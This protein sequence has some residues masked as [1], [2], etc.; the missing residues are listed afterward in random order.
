SGGGSINIFYQNTLTNSGSIV[1]TGGAGGGSGNYPGGA[2]GTGTTRSIQFNPYQSPAIS[3]NTPYDVNEQTAKIDVT[4]SEDYGKG[5]ST[6]LL[7]WGN[8][9]VGDYTYSTTLSNNAE[10]T[11]TMTMDN[12]DSL[13][14]AKTYYRVTVTN[15]EGKSSPINGN[16][17]VQKSLLTALRGLNGEG[18][19][20]KTIATAYSTIPT[21]YIE[22]DGNTHYTTSTNLGNSTADA[23]MLAIRYNGDVLIDAGVT[24]TPTAR[25]RGMFMYVDG[26]LTVNGT[27]SMTARGAANVS[28]DRILILTDSG[29]SYEIPAVG[30]AGAAVSGWGGTAGGTGTN[31]QT[32]GGGEGYAYDYGY[33]SAGTSYSGGTGGGGAGGSTST[34]GNSNGGAGGSSSYGG[35]AGNPGGTGN[36]S[37]GNG[38]G[39]LLIIYAKTIIISSTGSIQSKG[40][41]GGAGSYGG[42][43]SGGGSINIFYQN[44]LTNSGSIVA[45]GGAGGG[46]GNYPG[47]AGGTGTVRSVKI[48]N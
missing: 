15:N 39:G 7:E 46:S 19:G 12:L 16:F 43:G 2:G 10:G 18:N 40:S 45:T 34:N 17:Q 48:S 11:Y 3:A 42:G 44:T 41:A 23:R 21:E 6:I 35:G 4:I 8:D 37:G 13:P 5:N 27:I 28:G 20:D 32:G 24:L 25:K 29:T 9:M 22:V 14:L 38:T 1:A 30:G 26:A 36:A 33:G 47:G 31:G